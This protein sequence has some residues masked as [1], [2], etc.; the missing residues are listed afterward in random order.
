[1]TRD[2]KIQM[3]AALCP[4]CR[5]YRPVWQ[6]RIDPTPHVFLTLITCGVWVAYW[7]PRYLY[8]R[9]GIGWRCGVCNQHIHRESVV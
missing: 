7:W 3:G 8:N 9:W 6:F 2:I 5:T 4:K 1:M